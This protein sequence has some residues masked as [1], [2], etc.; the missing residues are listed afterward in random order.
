MR[1]TKPNT[2]WVAA[3]QAATKNRRLDIEKKVVTMYKI[4]MSWLYHVAG[5]KI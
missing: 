1:S 5:A 4:I 2:E 3:E